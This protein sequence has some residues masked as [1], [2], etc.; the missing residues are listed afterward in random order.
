MCNLSQWYLLV[1][2]H[3]GYHLCGVLHTEEI[4]NAVGCTPRKSSPAVGCTPRK[5]S[6]RWVAQRGDHLRGMLHTAETAEMISTV[7][8]TPPSFFSKFRALDS[9]VCCTPLR[10][11][12][13]Q[14]VAHRGVLHIAEIFVIE[15]LNK[16]ET[17]FKNTLACLS[18]AQ[19]GSNHEIN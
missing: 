18:G 5:S 4:I 3:C 12:P 17:V 19:M 13:S 2:A 15:Y 1:I 10:L 7:C 9:A 14:Y 6:L 16:I 11:S 8:C